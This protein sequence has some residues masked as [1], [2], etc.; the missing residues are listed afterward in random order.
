MVVHAF[1]C[2]IQEAEKGRSLSLVYIASS[3][4]ARATQRSPKA[5]K[6]RLA[7]TTKLFLLKFFHVGDFLFA[8]I[9]FI[10]VIFKVILIIFIMKAGTM[11]MK[12]VSVIIVFEEDCSRNP[13]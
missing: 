2:S 6:Q 3:R 11:H 12:T 9:G 4:T 1:N 13:A 8:H 10:I 7:G 5:N